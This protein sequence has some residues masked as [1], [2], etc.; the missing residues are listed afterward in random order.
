MTLELAA[1]L[2]IVAIVGFALGLV[3]GRGS[4]DLDVM[5]DR[6][7]AGVL[8][9]L[10]S[11]QAS[12][13]REALSSLPPGVSRSDAW[14]LAGRRGISIREAAEEIFVAQARARLDANLDRHHR[15]TRRPTP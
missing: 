14:E 9:D 15:R 11:A 2:T 7:A 1:F 13:D 12:D 4:R 8:A 5:L 3:V 10:V 6:A